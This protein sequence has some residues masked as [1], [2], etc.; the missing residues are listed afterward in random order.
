MYVVISDIDKLLSS[1]RQVELIEDVEFV[2]T[3]NGISTPFCSMA[4]SLIEY[5]R[6]LL[7][8]LRGLIDHMQLL[9]RLLRLCRWLDV[10]EQNELYIIH[11]YTPKC[12][13]DCLDWCYKYNCSFRWL[14][15]HWDN[16]YYIELYFVLDWL[17]NLILSFYW[18]LFTRPLLFHSKGVP[19]L[20]PLAIFFLTLILCPSFWCP[21]LVPCGH[22]VFPYNP[23]CY[24]LTC[25][26]FR[27]Y[28]IGY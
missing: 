22:P 9:L 17:I 21:M 20:Y 12:R 28:T 13:R 2:G 24:G 11:L 6:Y 10:A 3:T 4:D 25:L 19:V 14:I 23:A 18:S 27:Q 1:I 7:G 15:V 5:E 16:V 26:D 8:V